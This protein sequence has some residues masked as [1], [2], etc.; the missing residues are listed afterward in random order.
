M[1]QQDRSS[2]LA[3]EALLSPHS[4]MAAGFQGA[5]CKICA[6]LAAAEVA[7]IKVRSSGELFAK[8]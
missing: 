3:L 1:V 8:D 6:N 7:R 5:H 4:L 2:A